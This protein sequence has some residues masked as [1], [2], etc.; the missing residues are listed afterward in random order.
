MTSSAI[1]SLRQSILQDQAE[2][3]LNKIH[4]SALDFGAQKKLVK[5][6]DSKSKKCSELEFSVQNLENQITLK[7]RQIGDLKIELLSSQET[8][9]TLTEDLTTKI[10]LLEETA[11]KKPVKANFL[12][13]TRLVIERR[14]DDIER[15]WTKLEGKNDVRLLDLEFRLQEMTQ[16]NAELESRVEV[17]ALEARNLCQIENNEKMSFMEKNHLGEM[18]KMNGEWE[19]KLKETEDKLRYQMEA[20]GKLQKDVGEIQNLKAEAK[21]MEA[22]IGLYRRT[23]NL[24]DILEDTWGKYGKGR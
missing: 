20:N 1:Q 12:E 9:T 15:L 17:G 11:K 18:E 8:Q 6:L 14:F 16:K 19:K 23:D 2:S 21:L 5:E 3:N 7:N 4:Q 22:K 24:V 13:D 10:H